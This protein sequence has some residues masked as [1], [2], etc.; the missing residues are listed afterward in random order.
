MIVSTS[1]QEDIFSS[2]S[3]LVEQTERRSEGIG[4]QEPPRE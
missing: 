3:Q 4:S 2:G 1:R